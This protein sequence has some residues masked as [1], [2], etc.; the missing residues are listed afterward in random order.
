MILSK[1]LP[2]P[3]FMLQVHTPVGS[4]YS[5][6]FMSST[7]SATQKAVE[8]DILRKQRMLS[9]F[10]SSLSWSGAYKKCSPISLVCPIIFHFLCSSRLAAFSF[11]R[12]AYRE[13][14][15]SVGKAL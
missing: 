15:E 13:R 10:S 6:E 5:L 8:P 2:N 3:H 7:M 14:I 12:T 11:H 9:N 4:S 1:T